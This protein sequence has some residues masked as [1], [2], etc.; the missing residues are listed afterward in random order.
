MRFCSRLRAN[1]SCSDAKLLLCRLLC[2]GRDVA[3]GFCVC[4]LSAALSALSA[5]AMS[6]AFC[7]GRMSN[8]E[9]SQR[10]VV[11]LVP[12]LSAVFVFLLSTNPERLIN[13]MNLLDLPNMMDM[14]NMTSLLNDR[15]RLRMSPVDS[16]F[17]Y[18]RR[19]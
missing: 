1:L 11:S 15:D 2:R 14:T 8:S 7:F 5:V 6:I 10:R 18:D 9:L 19:A 4:D 3:I 12:Q 13:P 16:H 17:R